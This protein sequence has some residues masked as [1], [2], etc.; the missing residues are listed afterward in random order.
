MDWYQV[1]GSD[2]DDDKAMIKERYQ[3][4]LLQ[5]HPDKNGGQESKTFHSIVQAWRI[6]GASASR[7]EYDAEQQC[8]KEHSEDAM[9]WKQIPLPDMEEEADQ[10]C[11]ECRCGGD[12]ILSKQELEEV[13]TSSDTDTS[14]ILVNCDTCSLSIKINL[15]S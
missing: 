11:E 9:I 1:L 13:T 4:L 2:P 12:F 8:Q 3:Q 15:K 10:W 14:Y 5:H 7:R 6:L